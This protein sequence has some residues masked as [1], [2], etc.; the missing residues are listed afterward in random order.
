ML[1]EKRLNRIRGR[2]DA[3]ANTQYFRFNTPTKNP[4]DL[5]DYLRMEVLRK[6]TDTYLSQKEVQQ[7]IRDCA[8]LLIDP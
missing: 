8:E 5:D 6:D 3:N 7:R 1:P 2:L 4:I